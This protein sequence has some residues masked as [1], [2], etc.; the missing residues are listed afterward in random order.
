MKIFHPNNKTNSIILSI[1]SL[2]FKATILGTTDTIYII[3][4]LLNNF[5]YTC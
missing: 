5:V 1:K 3:R 2:I 4:I